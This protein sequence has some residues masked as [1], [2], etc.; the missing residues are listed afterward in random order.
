M[1][2]EFFASDFMIEAFTISALYTPIDFLANCGGLLGLFLG[3]SVLSSSKWII[4][5]IIH[6]IN[7]LHKMKSN[8]SVVPIHHNDTREMNNMNT[9][10]DSDLDKISN[11]PKIN[12]NLE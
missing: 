1:Y 10:N 7:V 6:L 11:A 9:I 2:M 3:F 8:N 4:N 12:V 5:S